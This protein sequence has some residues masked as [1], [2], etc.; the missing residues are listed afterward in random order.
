MDAE[1][2]LRCVRK[3]FLVRIPVE[4]ALEK[5]AYDDVKTA[6][7]FV[8]VLD[9]RPRAPDSLP[10]ERGYDNLT[11]AAA[12]VQLSADRR[13]KNRP[14]PQLGVLQQPQLQ[15]PSVTTKSALIQPFVP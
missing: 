3:R 8:D 11:P 2:V 9:G 12:N 7:Y 6:Q 5:P 4:L 15:S 10:L 13:R 1:F 14:C